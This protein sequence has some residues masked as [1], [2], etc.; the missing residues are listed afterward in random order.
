MQR[1]QYIQSV[2][3]VF[4]QLCNDQCDHCYNNSGPSGERMTLEDCL[5]IVQH[6][7]DNIDRLILSGGEPLA[8][9]KKL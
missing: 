7:P 6:L 3:W 2:Y 4:T 9:K 1:Y 5:K 8:E